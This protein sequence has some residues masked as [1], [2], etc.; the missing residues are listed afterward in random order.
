MNP[1]DDEL[2]DAYYEYPGS[3]D[4]DYFINYTEFDFAHD[5]EFNEFASHI[6]HSLD[7]FS[8]VIYIIAFLLGVPGNA[9]VIWVTGF[10]L[11]KTVTTQWFLNLAIADLVFVLFLPLSVAYIAL[12]YHWPFGIMLCK[13]NSFV[14]ILNMHSSILFLT[15]ISVDRCICFAHPTWAYRI[16]SHS[17]ATFLCLLVWAVSLVLSSPYLYFRDTVSFSF[18]INTTVCFSNYMKG[19]Q[20]HD[21]AVAR[22]TTQVLLRFF[23]GFLFPFI[24]MVVCYSLLLVNMKRI[25]LVISNKLFPI[26]IAVIIVFFVCW[27]PY[28]ILSILEVVQHS[29]R[30][31]HYFYVIRHGIPIASSLAFLNSCLNP[32]LYIFIGHNVKTL[33]RKSLPDMLKHTFGQLEYST[34]VDQ[35]EAEIETEAAPMEQWVNEPLHHTDQGGSV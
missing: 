23:F 30:S 32:I 1:I 19:S 34:F 3:L 9:L 2:I 29:S 33:L 4:T 11:K 26:T 8:I 24:T 25:R 17:S 31:F 35:S 21:T 12:E 22:H 6:E 7:I 5:Y 13:I 18:K 16:R 28:H 20:D 10:N 14:A 15:V 27:T